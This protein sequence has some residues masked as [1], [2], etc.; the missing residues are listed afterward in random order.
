MMHRSNPRLFKLGLF[1]SLTLFHAR[2]Q[3]GGFEKQLRT[4]LEQAKE[5]DYQQTIARSP[6]LSVAQRKEFM[7]LMDK[8]IRPDL[9]YLDIHSE[10]QLRDLEG[11]TRVQLADLNG[12][13]VP[14]VIFQGSGS[15]FCGGSGNCSFFI[16]E[17]SSHGY[18]KLLDV[19]GIQRIAID[20]KASEGYRDL[21]LTVHDSA[22]EQTIFQYRFKSGKYRKAN[23]YQ[24]DWEDSN[25]PERILKTPVIAL[26]PSGV[27]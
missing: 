12:D 6:A 27:S 20:P 16:F 14:E 1:A 15:E 5:L 19:P 13:G 24:A 7:S 11:K 25:H 3:S 2:A 21:F 10:S 9:T 17:K 4:R 8:E 18:R 23:C 22:Y 26:C